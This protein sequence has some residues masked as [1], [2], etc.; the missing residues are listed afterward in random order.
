MQYMGGK[1]A[2]AKHIVPI[3]HEKMQQNGINTYVEPFVG[4]ANVID[5]VTAERRIDCDLNRYIIAL[6]ENADRVDELPETVSR[7]HYSNVRE[8]Y[9]TDSG[10]Y[11][12]WY[13]GAIGAFASFNGKF[14]SGAWA[15]EGMRDGKTRNYFRERINSFKRQKENLTDV[16]WKAGDY[17]ETCGEYRDCLIYCDPPYARGTQHKNARHF[18]SVEFFEWCRRMSE[19]NIVLISEENAPEDFTCIMEVPHTYCINSKRR[20]STVEKLWQYNK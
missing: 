4:G 11:E 20:K 6:F 17:R 14:Y 18:D 13:V 2:L 5:R 12:D 7:E 19:H 1:H 3:I 15:A 16:E 8:C 9:N 10:K